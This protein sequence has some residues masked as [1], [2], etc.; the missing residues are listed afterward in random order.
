MIY[1]SDVTGL[2]L[3]DS[4]IDAVFI[5]ADDDWKVLAANCVRKLAAHRDEFTTDAVWAL[6]KKHDAFC[7][8]PEPRAMGAVMKRAVAE[9]VIA[10][11]DRA[12]VPSVR[13]ECHRRPLRVWR[14]L[15]R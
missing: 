1:H 9:N 2:T 7:D 8:T 13:P 5:A 4:A 12:P 3:R 15:W 11:A 10:P 14:S 6:I